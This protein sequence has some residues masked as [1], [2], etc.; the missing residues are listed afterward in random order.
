MIALRLAAITFLLG[1]TTVE[2]A[3]IEGRWLDMMGSVEVGGMRF[4]DADDIAQTIRGGDHPCDELVRLET[5]AGSLVA[6]CTPDDRRY[7]LLPDADGQPLV[8]PMP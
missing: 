6:T 5:Q 4:G 1:A 8:A 3:V 7:R 2:A